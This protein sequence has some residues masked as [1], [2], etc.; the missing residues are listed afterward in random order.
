MKYFPLFLALHNRSVLII[1][2]GNIALAKLQ[3]L[4]YYTNN[5]TIV[6][7]NI[8][9]HLLIFIKDKDIKVIHSKYDKSH[10]SNYDV[11]I[12]ATNDN[13]VNSQISED[14]QKLNKLVN[15]VDNPK[16]SDFI[17]GATVNRGNVNIAI[18]SSGVSPVL[19][20][21][22][23][24]KI[25]KIIPHNLEILDTFIQNNRSKVKDLLTNLQ[26]R[27]LFWQ[28]VIDG[29]IAQEVLSDN[30]NNAQILLEKKLLS[31]QN[32]A[33]SALY[34]IG[35]GPG[36]PDLITI[37]AINLL[38]KA[39]IVLHDRLVSTQI[40][41]YARKDALIINVGKTK[42]FHTFTQNELNHLIK[43]YLVDGNIVVRLKGGD[44][45]LFAHLYEEIDVAQSLQIP[46]HIVPGISAFSGAAAYSAIPLTLR[47][48]SRSV[49]LLTLYKKDMENAKYWEDLATTADTLVFYM[50]SSNAE[51][52][53]N[54][55]L[56]YGKNSNVSIA[57]IEQATTP[58]Q[59]THISTLADF[60][61]QNFISPSLIIIGDVVKFAPHYQWREEGNSGTYFDDLKKTDY[62]I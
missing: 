31:S 18:S 2:G 61:Q 57:V 9:N 38:S 54:N 11:I 21:M 53:V 55:L 17:F 41:D 62:A 34:I 33:K 26:S 49:R 22:I 59:K 15:I 5:I 27:R 10:I 37:K 44:P 3:T 48:T 36:D 16:I 28:E 32:N 40:L 52:I 23:K 7:D 58:Y 39:D 1:G 45:S 13:E 6:A 42:D 4:Y 20:R 43:K 19:S 50:S 30:V 14:A 24:Q 56:Q 12:G 29:N 60:T 47:D 46:Y 8:L 51:F 25:E 35:A